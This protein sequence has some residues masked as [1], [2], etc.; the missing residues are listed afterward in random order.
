VK[1]LFAVAGET[2]NRIAASQRSG[3]TIG[4]LPSPDTQRWTIRRK[5]AVVA[6]VRAGLITIEQACERYSLTVEEYLSWQR[7]ID[8]HGLRGLRVTKIQDYRGTSKRN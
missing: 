5:A 8:A 6:G 2:S 4:D 3:I 7:L 1:P